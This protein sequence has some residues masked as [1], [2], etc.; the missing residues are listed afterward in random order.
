MKKRQIFGLCLLALGIVG[1][2]ACDKNETPPTNDT[3]DGN[4]STDDNNE[5]N[6]VE[7]YEVTFDT[8][9]G[10][11]IDKLTINENG[12]V[13]LPADPVKDGFYFAGWYSD[14]EL[15]VEFD[16]NT[17]VTSNL[18]IYAKFL[19][20]CKVSFDTN[21]NGTIADAE[22]N[23]MGRISK[24]EAPTKTGYSFGGWY[25]DSEFTTEFDFDFVVKENMTLYARF[26][27]IQT[28]SFDTDGGTAIDSITYTE[29]SNVSLPLAA[30]TGMVF[31]HWV[32]ASNNEYKY[33][34][35][36]TKGITSLKAVYR[37]PGE[38]DNVFNSL[39]NNQAAGALTD[40]ADGIFKITGEVRG[41]IKTWTNPEDSSDT[42]T[43]DKSYKIGSGTASISATAPGNGT[44]SFYVQ[45][46]SSG[47]ASQK[48]IIEC[49]DGF[50]NEIEFSGKST[51][52]APYPAGSPVVRIDV[53]V[54]K[55]LTYT[56]KRV[57]GT[58]DIFEL[59]LSCKVL[60]DVVTGIK[61]NDAGKTEFIEGDKLSFDSVNLSAVHGD[62]MYISQIDKNAIFVDSSAVDMTKAGTYDV[63]VNYGQF[64]TTYPITVHEIEKIELGFN[65]TYK[66]RNS[67]NGTYVNGKVQTIYELN[68]EFNSNYLTVRATIKSENK[69]TFIVNSNVTYSGFSSKV[70][71]QRNVKVT[72]Y[73]NGKEFTE[74]YPV[75]VVDTAPYKDENG[76][77]V[78]TVNGKYN[79]MAGVQSG[80]NGNVFSTIGQALEFLEG[81][82][83][84][85]TANK[86]LNVMAGYYNEKL[87]IN[88]PNLTIIGAGSTKA[89]FAEDKAYDITTYSTATIIEWDSLY[90]IED[91]SGYSQITD[92]T[93]T[94]AVRESATN[95][96]IKNVTLSN[97]WNCEEVFQA[98]MTYL[99]EK[100]IAVAGKANDHR[101]LALIVQADKFSMDN[102]ALLGYQDTVEL[103]T[104]RQLITNT[105][106]SGNT[107]F[108]FGTNAAAYFYNC[109]IFVNYKV[110]GSGYITAVKGC[111]SGAT[112]AVTYGFIFDKCK[113]TADERIGTETFALGRPWGAYSNIAVI[114]SE[115]GAHVGKTAAT[116]Y[117]AMGGIN[118]TDAT[119]SYK[120]YN[121]TGA[122]ALTEAVAGMTM[123]DAATAA[124]YS[125]LTK[126]FAATN[127]AF[128]FADDWSVTLTK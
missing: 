83:I 8:N 69:Q 44:L 51:A 38:I 2:T 43:W 22:T 79:G 96:T 109:E 53:P 28:L 76:N 16:V 102:C 127:G 116:R 17:K 64:S 32:D 93:A 30:K 84:D 57:S 37:E 9:G 52:V 25:T 11:A 97:Y 98:E 35:A 115:I 19:Q 100:G 29:L 110:G 121:N 70:A 90:G 113:F 61:L 41:R 101:A 14:S 3:N 48:V 89:T 7:N 71:G 107:D 33:L 18:T 78:V 91:E 106:I 5:N 60:E 104:G 124:N 26:A 68:E 59:N 122:S 114:N 66:D 105:Y 42:K 80:K 34:P 58:I 63:V 67:Y 73:A 86:I 118:P 65:A 128:T 46:G 87:E 75:Y 23:I 103:M 82:N 12:T 112:D 62:N 31:S 39:A 55:G 6:V 47:A 94:V 125:D 120:E 21:G 56:I 10:T 95:V 117:V 72:F 1:I 81:T 77:Y 15:E 119:V 126:V 99:E 50:T 4:T 108:I 40:K 54:E 24:P 13:T 111:N 20:K 88:V 36:G 92:S 74:T 123:L 49:S 27:E 45:N 85:Q